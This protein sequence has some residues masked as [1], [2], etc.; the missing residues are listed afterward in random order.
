MPGAGAGI[1]K[2][3]LISYRGVTDA[4]GTTTSLECAALAAKPNYNNQ[5]V[6]IL[7][8]NC[9]G[10]SRDINAATTGGTIHVGSVFDHVIVAGVHFLILSLKP[11]TAEVADIEARLDKML[12]LARSAQSGSKTLTG[13]YVA[14]YEDSNAAPWMFMG[15]W[16]DL[17]NVAG[18]DTIWIRVSTIGVD[19]GAYVV[20]DETSYTGVQPAS[21]K[22]IRIDGFP[23]VYGVKIEAFQSAG[24]A[25][26]LSLDMEF[27]CAKRP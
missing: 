26:F 7:D 9:K 15:A 11:A 18:G 23:N 12:V 19:G 2:K 20:E 21:A 22:A 13:A 14:E 3:A 17:T 10:Q 6:I 27:Y 25:P 4:I 5:S 8:G 1:L 24:G 16:I